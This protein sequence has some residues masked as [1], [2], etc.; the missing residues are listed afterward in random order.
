[1]YQIGGVKIHIEDHTLISGDPQLPKLFSKVIKCSDINSIEAEVQMKRMY[2]EG[3]PL[4]RDVPFTYLF[5]YLNGGKMVTLAKEWGDNNYLRY[6][7]IA[8]E[9][10]KQVVMDNMQVRGIRDPKL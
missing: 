2:K 6:R 4:G 7:A 5:A 8:Q 10:K 1:M 3:G 9:L